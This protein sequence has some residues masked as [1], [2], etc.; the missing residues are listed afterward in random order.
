MPRT[1]ASS[2]CFATSRIGEVLVNLIAPSTV[3]LRVFLCFSSMSLITHLEKGIG[4]VS[5][6][7]TQVPSAANEGYNDCY[8]TP[9]ITC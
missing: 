7:F 3:S 8:G 5:A 6:V 9:G 2:A 4:G 1:I